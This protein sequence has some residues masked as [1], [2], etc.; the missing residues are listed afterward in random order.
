MPPNPLVQYPSLSMIPIEDVKFI[1]EKLSRDRRFSYTSFNELRKDKTFFNFF[2]SF[3]F[4]YA[5]VWSRYWRNPHE[6][7]VF[8][9]YRCCKFWQ[10]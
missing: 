2:L 4:S 6:A 5:M 9:A 10:P 7:C 8:R 3:T 1:L